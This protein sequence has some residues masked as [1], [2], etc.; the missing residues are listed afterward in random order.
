VE[1][2]NAAGGLLGEKVVLKVMDDV[3]DPKQATLLAGQAASG[4]VIFVAGHFCSNTSLAA[5]DV[6]E[7][8]GVLMISPA[9]TNPALTQKGQEMVFRICGRDDQQGVVAANYLAKHFANKKIA[10]I[11]DRS[12]YGRGLAEVTK[13]ELNKQ[14]IKEVAFEAITQGERDFSSLITLLKSKGVEVLYVGGY[15]TETGLI[16]RQAAD[17]GYPLV[18]MAGDSLIT[19][20]YWTI[21]GKAGQGT[22]MT[23]S[24]DPRLNP[25]ANPEGYTF[26]NYAAIQVF[27]EAVKRTKSKDPVVLAENL[28][29]GETFPTI[30]GN[31]NFDAKGDVTNPAYTVYEWNKDGQYVYVTGAKK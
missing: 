25:A 5:A 6:Y 7:E 23:F 12:S 27:A 2:L 10:I 1:D 29:K 20:E 9:S 11:H 8:N 30:I 26:Y 21:T 18:V 13:K 31:L 4:G 15:H 22:L 19:R 14:G 3:C 24:P 28:K 16:K 17:V